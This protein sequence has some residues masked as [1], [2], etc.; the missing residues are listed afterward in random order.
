MVWQD[1]H[2]ILSQIKIISSGLLLYCTL[3]INDFVNV[4]IN[5]LHI[6]IISI[7]KDKFENLSLKNYKKLR[8]IIFRQIL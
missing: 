2:T 8:F 4:M 5:I 7:K 1:L 6:I 3:N